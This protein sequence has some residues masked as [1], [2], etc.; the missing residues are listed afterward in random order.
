MKYALVVSDKAKQQIER[1]SWWFF[2]QAPGLEIKF[3]NELFSSMEFIQKSP[4]KCQL[5]YKN[6]RIKFL[7]KFDIG[8]HYIIENQTVFILAV[9]HMRQNSDDWF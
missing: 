2:D 8:I 7:K 3:L 4:L 1:M 6:I 9:Y 5:R